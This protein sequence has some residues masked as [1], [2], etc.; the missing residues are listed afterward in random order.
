MNDLTLKKNGEF[1]LLFLEDF[2]DFRSRKY[3]TF[4]KANNISS[5]KCLMPKGKKYQVPGEGHPNGNS[6]YIIYECIQK[7]LYKLLASKI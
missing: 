7:K 1:T 2:N 5:I 3:D 6:H 4:L